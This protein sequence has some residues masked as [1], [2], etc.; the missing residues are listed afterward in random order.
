M[1]D[2]AT[3]SSVWERAVERDGDAVFLIFERPDGSTT[4]WTYEQFDA[5]VTDVA[6]GLIQRG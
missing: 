3:F 4:S 1:T 6:A 5:A 2:P